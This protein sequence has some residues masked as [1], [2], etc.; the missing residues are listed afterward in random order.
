MELIIGLPTE[1]GTGAHSPWKRLCPGRKQI[2]Q[3]V[4]DHHRIYMDTTALTTTV[5][6]P[7]PGEKKTITPSVLY[8]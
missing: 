4:G 5:A 2:E 3:A 8:I 7:T 1:A 6:I